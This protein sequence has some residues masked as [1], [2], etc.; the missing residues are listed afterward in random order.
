MSPILSLSRALILVAGLLLLSTTALADT[1]PGEVARQVDEL[2]LED[3][4]LS[5]GELAPPVDDALF[6]RRVH[7]D[8]VGTIPTRDEVLAFEADEEPEK[9]ERKVLELL[10]RSEFGI[11]QARYWRDVIMARRLEDRAILAAPALVEDLAAWINHGRGWDEIA[12][13]FITA[14]GKISTDGAAALVMA[15][16][17]RTEEIAAEVSRV[18]LG[19]Q[20]QCAQ[21]HDHPWDS[22][23]REQF[24]EFAACFPRIA[25]RPVRSPIKRSLE[26]VANDAPQRRRQSSDSRRHE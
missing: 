26:V 13:E 1:S 25:V 9:R 20:I 3:L 6:L 11:A 17:G 23:R 10:E 15:Q 21:C 2:I 5:P 24:H 7:L 12:A 16:D 18:F 4:G 8:L 19:I 22:W 14:T